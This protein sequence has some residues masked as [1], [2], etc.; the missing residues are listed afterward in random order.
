MMKPYQL[1][2]LALLLLST[3]GAFAQGPTTQQRAAM[4]R[5]LWTNY[6]FGL[7][8]NNNHFGNMSLDQV[9]RFAERPR[10]LQRDLNGFNEEVKSVTYSVGLF[11]NVGL[12]P[13]DRA[14]GTYRQNRE[15]R[16]GVGLH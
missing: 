11:F 8:L 16:L 1:I 15:V 2:G 14:T 3:G 5:F 7:G 13:L 6:H 10:Q 12:S 4:S 9:M